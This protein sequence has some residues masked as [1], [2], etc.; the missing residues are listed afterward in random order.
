M[1]TV[2]LTVPGVTYHLISRFCD[3]RWLFQDDEERRR[4]LSLL[5]R[6]LAESDWCCFCYALMSN[7]IHLGM[8]AGE[9]PLESWAKRAHTPFAVWMNLRHD[10]IGPVFVRGPKDY[11]VPPDRIGRLIAYIHNNPVRAGVVERANE[12][13][14]TSHLAYVGRVQPPAWL[15]V[16]RGM[17]LGEFRDAEAFEA[18]VDSRPEDPSR[19]EVR[20]LRRQASRRGVLEF[21][22]PV[23]GDLLRFPI[24]AR[25]HAT[26]RID[27][28]VVV[29]V[30][31][32]LMRID[33]RDLTSRSRSPEIVA[34]RWI[35]VHAAL[36]VG[37]SGSDIGAA[38]G[39]S[40]SGVSKI[41]HAP[42]S[43]EL[44]DARDEVVR[45][46]RGL[47]NSRLSPTGIAISRG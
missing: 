28:R 15:D 35:A 41:R 30:A 37:V 9:A 12:S 36:A 34:T 3:G 18:F 44:A 21:G 32:A 8:V 43:A 42:L 10:R 39:L 31:A 29:G 38:L 1:R 4:Y 19:A 14:W 26:L 27:P 45:R 11:A 6:A 25:P 24:I 5:G 17:S 46:V 2:R 47:D 16:E 13:T 33:G 22:T 23:D 7:H 20:G 40:N